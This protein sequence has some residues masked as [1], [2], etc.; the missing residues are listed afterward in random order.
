[1][2]DYQK[3]YNDIGIKFWETSREF[4]DFFGV[5]LDDCS[6]NMNNVWDIAR[7]ETKEEIINFYRDRGHTS[8]IVLD[9]YKRFGF[10]REVVKLLID[11][12]PLKNNRVLD[13]GCGTG[14]LGIMMATLGYKVDFLEVSD[15]ANIK[16]LK[17][18]LRDRYLDCGVL[19]ETNKL[20]EY[21]VVFMMD[22]LE[23]LTNP[24][25]VIQNI[26]DSLAPGGILFLR[27][28]SDESG[29]DILTESQYEKNIEPILINNYKFEMGGAGGFW[30]RK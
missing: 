5:S 12:Y 17:R 20:G 16:F 15:S 7:P 11:E 2:N 9:R 27:W 10:I 3:D 29:N 30:E 8:R 25:E 26:T 28:A 22:V 23:H 14:E 6:E 4:E 19:D 1:M 21:D 18:R 13:Y 24:A